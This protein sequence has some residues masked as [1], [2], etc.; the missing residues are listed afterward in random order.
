MRLLVI[1]LLSTVAFGQQR[2]LA[3][4]RISG[5][6]VRDSDGAPLRR[7]HVTLRPLEAGG[8]ALGAD[9]DDK[10]S[11]EIRDIPRG[12]YSLSAQRDG[13]LSTSIFLR[14]TLRMPPQFFLA[15][16][17]TMSQVTFRLKPWATL[18]GKVR[19]N[20]GDPAVAVPV[21]LYREYHIRGRHGF[22]AVRSAVTDDHGDY[23]VYDLA[24][25]EYYVA[26]VYEK[27]PAS[28]GRSGS[29]AIGCIGTRDSH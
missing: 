22:T 11:F 21:E 15:A 26:A 2:P 14:G 12:S 10:G 19:F 1:A 27:A 24:P 16:G 23:R 29:A 25:G 6:V 18:A 9:A 8:P 13:Y 4:S 28:R 5:V 3:P 20:D 17:Q 7:A